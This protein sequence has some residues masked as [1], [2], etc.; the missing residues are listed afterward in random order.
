[1]RF[2][3]NSFKTTERRVRKVRSSLDIKIPAFTECLIDVCIDPM[4]EGQD[5]ECL[6]LQP[7]PSLAERCSVVMAAC[8]TDPSQTKVMILNP[9]E[10]VAN[11]YK[12][13]VL[14]SAE[15]IASIVAQVHPGEEVFQTKVEECVRKT[16]EP[17]LF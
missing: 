7:D 2:H 10:Q 15:G 11:I 3:C 6:L 1:M 12:N 14:G 17:L 13:T 8:L 9:F 5:E 4:L 16:G